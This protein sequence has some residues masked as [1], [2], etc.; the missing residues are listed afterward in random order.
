[1]TDVTIKRRKM[2]NLRTAAVLFSVAGGMVG[3]SY[4]AVPLYELFCQVTGFGGTTQVAEGKTAPGA[5]SEKRITIS[6]DA[7]VAR[8]LGWDFIPVQSKV[9][10]RA[11]EQGLAFYRAENLQPVPVTGTA[12]FNVTPH[13][14]GIYFT[15]IE[16]FCFTE[17]TLAAGQSINMPVQF[18]VDPEIWD[19]PNTKDLTDIVLSYTF[20]RSVDPTS[21]GP[22]TSAVAAPVNRTGG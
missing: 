10:L 6:F 12:S 19:D 14:A 8:D 17:Q 20:Y 4:A 22:K 5:V 15:K 18:Y 11:G 21:V 9:A 13:K 3:L 16:C 2:R 7:N 1:M